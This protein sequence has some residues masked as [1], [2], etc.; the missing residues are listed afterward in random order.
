VVQEAL[1]RSR[2][3]ALVPL[4]R[5]LTSYL[6]PLPPSPS[7]GYNITN[8]RT[9]NMIR[10]PFTL[11][12]FQLLV[13]SLYVLPLWLTGLRK[14]PKLSMQELKTV[15]PMGFCHMASHLA[16]VISLGA[17]AVSFTH[18]VKA[19]EP[20]FTATLS[21]L[22]LGQIFP[23]PVYAALLPVVGGVGLAS[24]HELNFS[25]TAFGGAMGSNLAASTRGIL[26]KKS[27]G[28]PQGKNMTPANLYAVLTMLATVMLLPLAAIFEG[29]NVAALWETAISKG[30]TPALIAQGSI[31][32]G[33]FFYLYNEVAFLALNE[34]HPVT[35]AVG[36]TFK[37]VFVIASSIFVFRTPV[38]SRGL[39]G[40]AIAILGV[41][42]YSLLKNYY[43]TK[44]V[45]AKSSK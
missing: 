39:L 44:A 21:A 36:N 32:S 41:M 38:T 9:L 16:A 23:L 18:I 17:G 6:L 25:W 13:G 28:K 1:G 4:S 5:P 26:A 34:V 37:R 12:A 45:V 40:S 14:A 22:F 11:S 31:L 20:L 42:V 29:R 30:A 7:I 19:A 27:M 2:T 35:H 3:K 8:K 43:S 24:L 15:M 10:I 33:L